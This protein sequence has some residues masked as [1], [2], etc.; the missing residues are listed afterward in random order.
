MS[1]YQIYQFKTKS[2]IIN[3]LKNMKKEESEKI[4]D[5]NLEYIVK[6]QL[7][8]VDEK[9]IIQFKEA[10]ENN[11]KDKISSTVNK[12]YYEYGKE[13]MHILQHYIDILITKYEIFENQE[14]VDR[15]KELYYVI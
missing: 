2:G 9:L 15:M 12:I 6:E 13:I 8:D 1:F 10:I 3:E 4:I 14:K 11:D 5:K 7:K